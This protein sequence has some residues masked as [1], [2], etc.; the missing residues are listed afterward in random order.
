MDFLLAAN[1]KMHSL[2]TERGYD[3]IYRENG[4]AHNYTTWRNSYIEGLEILFA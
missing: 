4:G 3:V 1:R 2:L